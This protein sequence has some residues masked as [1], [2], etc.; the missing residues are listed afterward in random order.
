MGRKPT[1]NLNLPKNMRVK[2]SRKGARHYYLDL[3]GKPRKWIALGSDY[4]AALRLYAEKIQTENT[5]LPTLVD[6]WNKFCLV[7][8]PGKA[9]NTIIHRYSLWKGIDEF[10][11][12]PT[13]APLDAIRPRHVQQFMEW[14]KDSPTSAN[15][16]VSLLGLVMN[17]ARVWGMTDAPNPCV[18][19]GRYKEK[20]RRD[21]YVSDEMYNKVYAAACPTL[22][23]AMDYAYLTGQRP[24]DV[25]GFTLSDVQRAADGGKPVRVLLVR[26]E[27]TK[28]KLRI[29]ITGRLAKLVAVSHRAY[30]GGGNVSGHLVFDHK[31]KAVSCASLR[32]KF[33]KARG[34]AGIPTDAFQFRDLRAKAGTDVEN[35]RSMEAA[36]NLLAHTSESMTR[37]YVRN[38]QGK[39]VDPTV[40]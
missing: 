32:S 18:G 37:R 24:G 9:R 7:E 31:G 39:M 22:R 26:Q 21:V 29:R 2:V 33:D 15:L 20:G 11:N 38:R 10:F 23:M 1:V 40:R 4:I 35:S 3:G 13:P 8:M 12:H 30:K 5:T 36:K 25:L 19:V 28:A 17:K 27:K 6:A 34:A 16:Q 14:R